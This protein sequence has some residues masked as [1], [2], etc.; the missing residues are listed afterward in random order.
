MQSPSGKPLPRRA[1]NDTPPG[2]PRPHATYWLLAM[3]AAMALA[4]AATLWWTLRQTHVL[5]QPHQQHDLWYVSSVHN[6]LARVSLLARKVRAR[7]A[8]AQDLQ[9]RLEV[10][11]GTL[12]TS[13]RGPRV[14][15]Q[16]REAL[17]EAA[18]DLDSLRP[19][20]ERWSTQ[21]GPLATQNGSGNTKAAAAITADIVR[22]S[23]PLLDRLRK[24]VATVH[25]FSAQEANRA[26]QQ[27]S[28]RFFVLSVVLGGLLLGTALLIAKLVRDT[29]LTRAASQQLVQANRQLEVRVASRTRKIEEG[30]ALLSFILDTSPSDV[31]L[32]EVESG[33]VHFINRQLTERLGLKAAPETLFLPELLHDP[34]TRER[35]TQALDR[36]GQVD[37][38]EALIGENNPSWS[39][40]SARL[41]EVEGQLAHL[42]WGFD[43]SAHKALEGQLRELATR[44]ALSGL[45]NRRAFLERSTALFDHCRRHGQPCAVLMIDIDHF[46]RIN[47]RHGHQMG[48]VAIRTCAEAIGHALR[49]ADLLGRLG[50]EEFAV[51]LPHATAD[52]ATVVAERIRSA[53]AQMSLV[54]PQGQPLAFTIS[55]G[56]AEMAAHHAGI[57]PLLVDADQALYRAKAT[58]R[59]KVLAYE[60]AIG[61]S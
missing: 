48:D 56:V 23:D 14:S 40:L 36:Y 27:L 6:E 17:P 8:S 7:E 52:S 59:N 42:L 13:G 38:M 2:Q 25:L 19:L 1:A 18:Q 57:E 45:L 15:T 61:Q 10:L 28:Q 46:K 26:R 3:V 31:V 24:V 60:A 11:L 34:E 4:T 35:F 20:V 51:L 58:G 39:S 12:D 32:A 55:I 49:D 54:S 50:G 41:I 47:D 30:R 37:A 16:L 21:L 44:D 9:E 53:T 22:Q 43:I 33:R 5:A 29:R